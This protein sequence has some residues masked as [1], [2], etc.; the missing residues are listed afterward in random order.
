MKIGSLESPVNGDLQTVVGFAIRFVV[1][2]IFA[3]DQVGFSGLPYKS[4]RKP[5]R[6]QNFALRPL[7]K[8]FSAK[9]GPGS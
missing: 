7:S 2:E 4:V 9:S 6:I 1:V 3:S 5:G 8:A